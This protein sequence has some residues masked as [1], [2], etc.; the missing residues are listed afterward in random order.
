MR[1]VTADPERH[2]NYAGRWW[3]RKV[4]LAKDEQVLRSALSFRH[5]FLGSYALGRLW[6][7]TDRIMFTPSPFLGQL[8][9]SWT[10]WV[11]EKNRVLSVTE[12]RRWWFGGW[13]LRLEVVGDRARFQPAGENLGWRAQREATHE[14]TEEIHKWASS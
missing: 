8:P 1:E 11:V 12:R 5:G 2:A 10:R 3:T 6:L 14:W 13:E 4:K 7:T 9:M